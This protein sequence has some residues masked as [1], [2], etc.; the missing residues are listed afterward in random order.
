MPR[1]CSA[2]RKEV[3]TLTPGLRADI[4]AVSGDVLTN[5]R[6]TERPL[7]VMQRGIVIVDRTSQPGE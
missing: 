4:V 2:S 7:L 1:A 5:I 6:A 3:G